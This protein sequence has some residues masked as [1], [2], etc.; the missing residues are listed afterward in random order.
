MMCQESTL[1]DEW[2]DDKIPEDH[3]SLKQS[4]SWV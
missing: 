4:E 3:M 1:K 2:S